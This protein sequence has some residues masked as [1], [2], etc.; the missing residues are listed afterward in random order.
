[1]LIGEPEERQPDASEAASATNTPPAKKNPATV[2]SK[3]RP[4]PDKVTYQD[5]GRW[6]DEL[7][8]IPAQLNELKLVAH[9]N[10]QPDHQERIANLEHRKDQLTVWLDGGTEA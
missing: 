5:R 8:N 1:V 6:S 2:P 4:R 7:R 9:Y 3:L 10:Q